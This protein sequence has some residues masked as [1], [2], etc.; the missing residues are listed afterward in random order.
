MLKVATW[1]LNRGG[2]RSWR[3]LEEHIVPDVA[4]VQQAVVPTG[5][6]RVVHRQGGIGNGRDWGSAVVSY[7]PDLVPIT[8][9]EISSTRID[10][11]R[12]W[13]GTVAI[14]EV[15]AAGIAPFT[16]VS[17][18]GLL[19]AGYEITTVHRILSDLTPLLDGE[20]GRRIVVGGDLNC[21]TQCDPPD[22]QRHVN[23]F[24]RVSGLGLVDLLE[25]TRHERTPLPDCPCDDAPECGHV[26]TH[27]HEL[28]TK[29]RQDDYLFASPTLADK[30]TACHVVDSGDPDPWSLSGHC[31]VIAE[32]DL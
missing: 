29:P 30:L 15:H 19:D 28:Y 16:V 18:Y 9:I 1:N 3:Y 25:R 2:E 8:H 10:L 27:R 31:P 26:E 24:E 12:T 6:D 32:F 5:M 20:Q 22:R 23:L 4:L 17:V 7:G 11:L 13:P 14:A 21:S